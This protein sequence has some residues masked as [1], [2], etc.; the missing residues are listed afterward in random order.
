MR[1]HFFFPLAALLLNGCN[2]ALLGLGLGAAPPAAVQNA[3]AV[4]RGPIDFALHSFDAALYAFD[5]AMD[6]GHP[7]PGSPQAK[8]LAAIGRKVLAA[9]TLADAAQ[10]AGSATSYEA[11]FTDANQAFDQFRQL[12]GVPITSAALDP[13]KLPHL[14]PSDRTAIL[15]MADHSPSA[16]L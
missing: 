7:A 15:A 2:P 6:A 9:L 1:K 10:R 13:A 16:G 14:S 4:A 11:A 3:A 8:Q 12:L 5:L